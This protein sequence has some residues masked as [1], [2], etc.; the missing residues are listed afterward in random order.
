LQ[1]KFFHTTTS[2][3][4][5]HTQISM[6]HLLLHNEGIVDSRYIEKTNDSTY[7]VGQRIVIKDIEILHLADII[8]KVAIKINLLV[9]SVPDTK[10][11]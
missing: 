9:K 10:K 7:K 4:S 8:I 3:L 5:L 1:P 6:G 11:N 2:R